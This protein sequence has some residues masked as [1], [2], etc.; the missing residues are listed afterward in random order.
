MRIEI[1]GRIVEVSDDFANL[2]PEQQQATVEQIARDMGLQQRSGGF[3]EKMNTFNEGMARTLGAPVDLIAGGLRRVGVPVGDNPV[4]GSAS[5]RSAMQFVGADPINRDPET[6]GEAVLMGAGEAVGALLPAGLLARSAQ[7]LGGVTGAVATDVMSPFINTPYRAMVA[8][9]LAGAGARAGERLADDASGGTMGPLGAIAGGLAAAAGPAALGRAV[10]ATA[11]A[12]PVTG[13]A[14]RGVSAAVAPF[15]GAGAAVRAQDRVRSLLADPDATSR[16]LSEAPI[17]NLTPAQQT[18]DPNLL[19]L[20]RAAA[21]SNPQLRDQLAERAGQAANDLESEFMAPARGQD[22]EAFRRF[23]EQRR[24]AFRARLDGRI[25]AARANAERRIEALSPARRESENALI[26]RDEIDRA[27]DSAKEQEAELWGRVPQDATVPTETARAAYRAIL[28]DTGQAQASD[29]PR[30]ASLLLGERFG[31]VETVREMYS[32][33]SRLRQVAREAASGQAP[34]RNRERIAN[35]IAEAILRDL[36]AVDAISPAGRAINDARTF[37]RAMKEAFDQGAVGFIRSQNRTGAD[38]VPREAS[39]S[40]TMGSGGVRASVAA[41]EIGRATIGPTADSAIEDFLRGR[42]VDAAVRQ[43]KFR[44]TAADS[45]LTANREV[46]ER[47]PGLTRGVEEARAGTR[48]ADRVNARASEIIAALENPRQN[49]TAAFLAA[50]NGDEIAA[51]VFKTRNPAEA[52]RA[53]ART[54]ARDRSGQA[55]DGLKGAFLDHMMAQAR[56]S[57]GATGQRNISGNNLFGAMQEP[58]VRGAMAQVFEPDEMRRLDAIAREFQG[59]EGSRRTEAL[60]SVMEDTP[61]SVISLLARTI[62]ARQGAKAGQGTSGA[63]LL[64]ANFASRRMQELLYRLT[65]DQAEK[66]IIDA[67]QD[68]ELFLALVNRSASPAARARRENRLREWMIGTAGV[69]ASAFAEEEAP[70]AR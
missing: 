63:S 55:L 62:A 47:F 13:A 25:E 41:Q 2:T 7:G 16:Q 36:G 30:E 24:S 42:F 68:R 5:L 18:N 38:A 51:A 19:A 48:S 35:E 54:A 59:I 28:Q 14:I 69:E 12:L 46:L 45:F 23:A 26:V 6:M 32:L 64:T 15:T 56:A 17:A 10:G 21:Q 39:L 66:L 22:S 60:P 37:T 61:N 34:N 44:E 27:Y 3:A 9:A 8:E 4:G 33:Y 49:V 67:V 29:I 43:G 52:A 50:H 58:R 40:R 31:E 53:L 70:P 57:Y 20:E 11:R 65:N 1:N